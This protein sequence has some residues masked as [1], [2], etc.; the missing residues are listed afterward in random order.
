M[1]RRRALTII[2]TVV[3]A[4]GLFA[5]RTPAGWG[6]GVSEADLAALATENGRLSSRVAALETEQAA[7][8]DRATSQGMFLSY[9]ATNMPTPP[10]MEAGAARVEGSVVIEGG[11][12]CVGG[13]AGDTVDIH[14]AYQAG[15]PYAEVTEMRVR[16][17]G[18]GPF[19]EVDLAEE[20]WVPFMTSQTVPFGVAINWVGFYVA[21]Q[22]RDALGD[23]SPVYTDDISVEGMPPTPG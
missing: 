8:E 16:A 22:F 12:C 7:L 20:A 14:I 1:Q 10:G 21:V 2:M 9:L 11:T 3:L 5:C 15:S 18:G 17:G 13:T 19:T 4:T 6:S 23:L